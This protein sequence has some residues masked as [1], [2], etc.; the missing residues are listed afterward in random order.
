MAQSKVL[1]EN[2]LTAS[3]EDKE[4]IQE[5]E[6]KCKCGAKFM[7]R[8]KDEKAE[9][10]EEDKRR[11][12]CKTC[13]ACKLCMYRAAYK[14]IDRCD[15]CREYICIKCLNGNKIYYECEENDQSYHQ[16]CSRDCRNEW[17]IRY[18]FP[19][20]GGCIALLSE[21]EQPSRYWGRYLGG[22]W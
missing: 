14:E 4:D 2:Q 10:D 11:I 17:C 21:R 16:F 3:S 9:G 8:P 20:D 7:V 19:C 13:D 6:S 1:M 22:L 5:L 18:V 12:I 15:T